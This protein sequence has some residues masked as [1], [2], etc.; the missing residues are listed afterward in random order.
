MIFFVTRPPPFTPLNSY[1][2]LD[3]SLAPSLGS[4]SCSQMPHLFTHTQWHF[5]GNQPTIILW[6]TKI[7]ILP[8]LVQSLSSYCDTT[9]SL[10]VDV[11]MLTDDVN[12]CSEYFKQTDLG[13][14]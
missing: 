10:L 9:A 2:H 12:S 7:L 13:K 3:R 8:D 11:V 6:N 14:V 4:R 5:I 1:F